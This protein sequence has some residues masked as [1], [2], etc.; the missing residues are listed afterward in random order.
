M[1]QKS[2]KEILYERQQ[3]VCFWCGQKMLSLTAGAGLPLSPTVDHILPTGTKEIDPTDQSNCRA[4]C[5]SC[6]NTRSKFNPRAFE[7]GRT[8]LL[9][10]NKGL[11]DLVVS[12]EKE[13]KRLTNV[14][15][16]RLELPWWKRIFA[17]YLKQGAL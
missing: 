5:F 14:L 3:G 1:S 6:N 15:L 17:T 10:Q 2:L 4:S 13:I 12:Q 8:E 16:T 11:K 9:Q 7:R